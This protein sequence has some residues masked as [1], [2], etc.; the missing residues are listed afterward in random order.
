MRL[1]PD[2]AAEFLETLSDTELAALHY[3][4]RFWARDNQL[5][6]DGDEWTIWMLMAGRGYGKTRTGAEFVRAEVEAGRAKRIA[7][8]AAT[9][10]DARDVMIEGESG[11]LAISPPW[12]K[13][14]YEPT[15]RR[16]TWPNGAVATHYSAEEPERLRGP[17]HDLAWGD[18]IGSWPSK[19]PW[20]QL[21]FGLR[22][23]R[24]PR[25]V[26]TTTPRPTALVREILSREDC[27]VTR[28][29]TYENRQNLAKAFLRTVVKKYEGTRLGRQ[30][31]MGELLDDTPGALW[32][33]TLIDSTRIADP[34]AIPCDFS[35]V[36]VGV[37]P[38]VTSHEE[39][40]ETGVIVAARGSG[41]Y[42]DHLYF[43]RD[44]SGRHPATSAS[45]EKQ[46]W[47]HVA[48]RAFRAHKADR[49]VAE[50]NNGGDLVAGAIR[51]I[52][53]DVPVETV[54]ATR[55]KAKRAE[56]VAMLWDQGRAHIVGAMP[57]L[58]DQM[59]TYVPDDRTAKSPDRMDA[60][61]WAGTALM[62][63]DTLMV[64]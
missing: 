2:A 17:Q 13:P 35:R 56:P 61:V 59:T 60:L 31:L 50:R 63:L 23:G 32:S 18:E 24:R 6:P 34:K 9:A 14:V 41:A 15:K 48:V 27:V 44:Y 7:L 26:A 39:S 64:L 47:A 25:V 45:G 5:P 19:D 51:Q 12:N 22:L 21:M 30:E 58:E 11:L 54:V 8:L 42:S 55:G 52:A 10:A 1:T 40:D 57:E 20:D 29:T 16:L 49:I 3:E 38:A 46:T 33:T 36:V 43:F 62:D 37:D 4:W 53:P 28:G